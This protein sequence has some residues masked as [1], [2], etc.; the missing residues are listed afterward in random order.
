MGNPAWMICGASA[1]GAAHHRSG[2]PNQDAIGW[3]AP[4]WG[5]TRATL[6]VSDGHGGRRH[7]H[8]HVG[9]RLAI[10]SALAECARLSET[11]DESGDFDFLERCHRRWLA[12]VADYATHGPD[13]PDDPVAYGATLVGVHFSGSELF[14]FQIGDGDIVVARA[15]GKL[16]KPLP[17]DTG[18]IGEQ[19][20]SLCEQ[21]ASKVGRVRRLDAGGDDPI[22]F[23]MASTDGVAKSFRDDDAFIDLAG[24]FRDRIRSGGMASIGERLGQWLS[25][26]SGHGSGDDATLGFL[27]RMTTADETATPA[28]ISVV[29]PAA[30]ETTGTRPVVI[31]PLA[32]LAGVALATGAVAFNPWHPW[33][34]WV[35]PIVAAA[36]TK[37]AS[38]QATEAP[39]KPAEE[40]KP[41]PEAKPVDAAPEKPAGVPQ[42]AAPTATE[43]VK[44]VAPTQD[45]PPAPESKPLPEAAPAPAATPIPA[46]KPARPEDKPRSDPAKP[47]TKP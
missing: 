29:R 4:N 13:R 16:E 41:Q 23:V 25:D 12:A 38:P 10:E 9:S 14:L 46:P 5:E 35:E 36:P 3:V 7:T 6:V 39:A 2:A 34:P 44:Q 17:D 27:C 31:A 19:T 43:P 15:S 8:S 32:F 11:A 37:P 21:D 47:E 20:H 42:A 24:Q 1:R 22:T 26:L 40:P 33:K 45:A 18:L 30:I 28:P